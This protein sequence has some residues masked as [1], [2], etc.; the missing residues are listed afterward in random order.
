MEKYWNKCPQTVLSQASSSTTSNTPVPNKLKKSKA[1]HLAEY[2]CLHQEIVKRTKEAQGW[3]T[4]LWQYR[5]YFNEVDVD[6]DT[7]LVKLWQVRYSS[8]PLAIF[9]TYEL[10]TSFLKEIESGF[11]TI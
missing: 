3:Q 7:D 11:P 8:L 10:S 1:S 5:Q 4:V 6:K 9:L 2:N